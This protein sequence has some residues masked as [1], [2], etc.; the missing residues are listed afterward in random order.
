M[1]F[2]NITAQQLRAKK[3][4]QVIKAPPKYAYRK[5]EESCYCTDNHL[6]IFVIVYGR[7]DFFLSD[8]SIPS[9]YMFICQMVYVMSKENSFPVQDAT[10]SKRHW[11]SVDNGHCRKVSA[12][13]FT[14]IHWFGHERI[15]QTY[16]TRN[17]H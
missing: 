8:S 7:C 5:P 11:K 12:G 6:A 14:I 1:L 10:E 17:F 3:A 9:S 2:S 15:L 16:C 4:V 13:T